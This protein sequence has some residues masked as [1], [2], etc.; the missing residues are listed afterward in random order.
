MKIVH[1]VRSMNGQTIGTKVWALEQY[2]DRA[3]VCWAGSADDFRAWALTT[4]QSGLSNIL[5]R[6]FC[7]TP[8]DQIGLGCE[9]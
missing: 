5:G 8:D 9:G 3:C 6:A 4:M 2:I 1:H 7:D